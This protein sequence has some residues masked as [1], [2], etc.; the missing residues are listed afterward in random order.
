MQRAWSV[1]LLLLLVAPLIP[2][3]AYLFAGGVRL[4]CARASGTCVLETVRGAGNVTARRTVPIASIE[5][6]TID[7]YRDAEGDE[8]HGI[9]LVYDGEVHVLDGHSSGAVVDHHRKRV[10]VD[11]V[12]AFLS[13]AGPDRID[14]DETTCWPFWVCVAL[15]GSALVLTYLFTSPPTVVVDHAR[16][17]LSIDRGRRSTKTTIPLDEV[18]CAAVRS[19][20]YEGATT[21]VSGVVLERREKPDLDLTTFSTLSAAAKDAFASR[22]NEALARDR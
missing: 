15:V 22:I 17:S 16:R 9:A 2:S 4:S 12:N 1:L 6:A 5:R 8:L 20:T 11:T 10:F 7:S 18:K 21:I 3:V 14:L 13:G 19:R